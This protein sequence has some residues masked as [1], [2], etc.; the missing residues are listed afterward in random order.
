MGV[1][2][3]ASG[4]AVALNSRSNPSDSRLILATDSMIDALEWKEAIE[5]QIMWVDIDDNSD[6]DDGDDNVVDDDNDDA[7]D[8]YFL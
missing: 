1:A 3:A 2:V 6:F 5:K 7:S 4:G 8:V